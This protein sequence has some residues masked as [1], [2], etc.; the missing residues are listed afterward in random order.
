MGGFSS[1]GAED[2]GVDFQGAQYVIEFSRKIY[3]LP[4]IP[5]GD[6]KSKKKASAKKW[7]LWLAIKLMKDS[8]GKKSC[9]L[10]TS[11]SPRD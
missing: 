2:G 8:F 9:L 5:D 7:I 4:S 6:E 1:G 3:V 11:P 10:Y